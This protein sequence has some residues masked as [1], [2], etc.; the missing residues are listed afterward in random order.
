MAL[1]DLPKLGVPRLSER[2]RAAVDPEGS[3]YLD[4]VDVNGI[5]P[6]SGGLEPPVL[7]ALLNSKLLDFIFRM[8]SVPFRGAFYSANKQ[9]IAPL[10]IRIPEG[11]QAVHL[12]GMAEELWHLTRNRNSETR[13]FREWL[14]GVTETPL[15][16]IAGHTALD[17]YEALSFEEILALLRRNRRQ[18]G[19]NPD[20]RAFAEQ[21]RGEFGASLER[22]Q[23]LDA[24]IA[25]EE[26]ALEDAVFDLYGMSTA[27]RATINAEYES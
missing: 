4:N 26:V 17:S 3:V 5:L 19:P 20:S 27:Q 2:L 18:I 10:P 15:T 8:G 9:F 14:S 24:A 23:P 25:Q 12:G 16:A 22:L 21:L 11:D 6:R 1:H 13:G 7:A